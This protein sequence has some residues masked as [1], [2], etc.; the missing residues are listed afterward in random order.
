MS[1]KTTEI[2]SSEELSDNVLHQRLFYPYVE[3]AK[4][5]SG[6]LLEIGCGFGRGVETLLPHIDSYT[7]ID[8]NKT[9]IDQLNAAHPEHHFLS[10]H[11][12]PLSGIADEQF[13]SVVTFQVIEHIEDDELFLKE[14]H[15]VL[16][17]GGKAFITT[18]N[19]KWTLT[20][21]P[22]HVREYKAI[23]LRQLLNRF[24]SKVEMKAISGDAK[25]MEYYERNKESVKKITR[26]D[27]LN[28][29]YRLPR[30]LLQVP[31]ELA[32]RL[33]R[34]MLLKGNKSLVSDVSVDNYHLED[35]PE[36]GFDFFCMVE[37]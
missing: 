26:F 28:L 23:E 37:K 11:I 12:P 36:N 9:L 24:F 10:K 1:Y 27:V 32:N 22:W 2:T 33:N 34:K 25:I 30:S 6:Q 8:K 5:V 17:P 20:R 13:D 3:T 15:R 29:Q 4:Q 18:P 7:A 16:K 19:I 35:N 31:Y 21:N 14:I